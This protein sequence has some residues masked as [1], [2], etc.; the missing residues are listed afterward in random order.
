MNEKDKTNINIIEKI[1]QVIDLKIRLFIGILLIVAALVTDAALGFA[2]SYNHIVVMI[3]FIGFLCVIN[4]I[5]V[6]A[7]KNPVLFIPFM[8]GNIMGMLLY[9]FIISRF[10]QIGEVYMIL[11]L[12]LAFLAML[13]MQ[14]CLIAGAP[15]KKRIIGGIFLNIAVLAAAALSSVSTILISLLNG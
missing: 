11:F 12:V 13:I 14:I 7:L 2:E 1:D 5:F 4:V 10:E 6:K 15:L 3:M 9:M 8:A